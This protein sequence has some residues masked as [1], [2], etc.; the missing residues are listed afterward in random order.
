MLRVLRLA[1]GACVMLAAL[2]CAASAPQAKTLRLAPIK[3]TDRAATFAVRSLTGR[4]L[5][6]AKLTASGG[7][8]RRVKVASVRRAAAREVPRLRVSLPLSW[9]HAHTR[10]ALRIRLRVSA[11]T[12]TGHAP[13]LPAGALWR[14]DAETSLAAEWASSSSVPEAASP[15]NPDSSRIAQQTF[16]AQGRRSYRFE[17]RDGDSSFGERVELGQALPATSAYENRWFRAGEDRW[18]AMQYYFPSDWPGTQTWQTVL[19]IKPVSPGGGG[20]DIGVDA[21]SDHLSFYGN[22]NSWGSTDG[23]Y[24]DGGGPLAGGAYHLTRGHWIRLTW[25]IVFSASASTGSLEVFGDLGDG[26]GMRT[27]VPRRSRPTMKYGGIGGMDP[28]HLRVG[29]YRDPA[30][31]GTQRLYVDGVTVAKTRAAAESNAYAPG[32]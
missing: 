12:C 18:I 10:K 26:Q 21:G 24:L 7:R 6:S 28:V 25:H 5:V 11:K 19:Q 4:T 29:I 30:M 2:G 13:P 9:R 27:L 14:A 16:R 15:P 17:L 3:V 32:C 8:S 22:T 31:T 23:A 1:L 20:P